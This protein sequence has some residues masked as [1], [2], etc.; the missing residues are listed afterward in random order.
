M[1]IMFVFLLEKSIFT[2]K[3]SFNESSFI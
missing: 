2:I 1:Q 3:S